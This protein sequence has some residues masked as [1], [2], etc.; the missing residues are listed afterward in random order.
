MHE[1]SV[2]RDLAAAVERSLVPGD[3]RVLRIAVTLGAAAGITPESL[4][5]AFGAVTR[6]T[7]ME[8]A[9]LAIAMVPA[10]ARCPACRITFTFEDVIG[11]CPQCGRAGDEPLAGG[12][13]ILQEIEVADA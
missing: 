5:F 1:L 8:G 3:G 12:E 2:A 4:R 13:L 9:E 6:G 11:R 10:R 7:R